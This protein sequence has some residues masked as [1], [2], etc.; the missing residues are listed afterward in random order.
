MT[1]GGGHNR[2]GGRGL[3]PVA[4]PQSLVG[5]HI[6]PLSFPQSLAEIHR[7]LS[8]PQF[9]DNK[10]RGQAL[11]GNPDRFFKD[12]PRE[13]KAAEPAAEPT[14]HSPALDWPRRDRLFFWIPAFAGMT[15]E[16]R[17]QQSGAGIKR[18]IEC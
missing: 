4:G 3:W 17:A 15:E 12:G 13:R 6:T 9:P 8:F 18:Q 5:I 14:A 11:S 10:R 7:P 2:G 16:G 1:E